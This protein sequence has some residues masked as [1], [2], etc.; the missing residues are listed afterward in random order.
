MK[1]LAEQ[2]TTFSPLNILD[3]PSSI[4]ILVVNCHC[5]NF[6]MGVS[7]SK[8]LFRLRLRLRVID[9]TAEINTSL[10]LDPAAAVSLS[11]RAETSIIYLI[12]S[13]IFIFTDT[14]N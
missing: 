1:I 14:Y 2:M 6:L 4:Y 9:L 13:H 5:T 7:I 12:I 3:N 10:F 8:Y 11:E